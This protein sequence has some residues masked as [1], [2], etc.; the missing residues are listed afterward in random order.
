MEEKLSTFNN[1]VRL[2][3]M[4]QRS[5]SEPDM[6]SASQGYP[7]TSW[8]Q[9]IHHHVQNSQHLC[10]SS[11]KLISVKIS[12][13]ISGISILI[14]FFHLYQGLTSDLLHSG[15]PNKRLYALLFSY[16]PQASPLSSFFNSWTQ[17]TSNVEQRSWRSVLSKFFHPPVISSVFGQNI[18]LITPISNIFNLCSS[19]NLEGQ[20][21]HPYATSGLIIVLSSKAI[22]QKSFKTVICPQKT[23]IQ[24]SSS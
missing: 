13:T 24:K 18:F 12:D 7:G 2:I 10:Q 14:L 23:D 5:P 21:S 8:N 3:S 1:V 22:R 9:K 11:A 19:V 4:Q 6:S 17:T 16:V 20:V 15:F